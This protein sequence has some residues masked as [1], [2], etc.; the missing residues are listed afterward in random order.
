[1]KK[2]L[3]IGNVIAGR[4]LLVVAIAIALGCAGVQ[5]A[6]VNDLLAFLPSGAQA[7]VGLPSIAAVEQAAAPLLALPMLSEVSTLAVALGGDTLA[8]GL[9]QSGV[10]VNAPAAAFVQVGEG[11]TIQG[12]GVLVVQDAAKLQETL[13]GLLGNAGGEITLP[14]DIKGRFAPDSGVGYFLQGDKFFV[15]TSEPLLQQL[16]TRIAEPAMVSYGK[17]ASKDEVVAF[18]RI[19]I[20]EQSNLLTNVPALAMFKPILDTIK[21]FSDE[22]ILAIGE[23]AGKA[24]IRLAAHDIGNAPIAA[25]APLSLHGFMD[26]G[27][28]AVMNL[29]I[30]PELVNALS[31]TLMNNEA[32]RQAGGYMRIASGMLG[33]ELALS[34]AGMKSE[35]VP[36]A[37]I[38]AKVKSAEGVPNLLKMLA[39]IE[40]PTYK[41]DQTDVY[42][43]P[44][45]SEGTDLHIATAGTTIVVTPGEDALKTAVGRFAGAAAGTG[46]NPEIVNKGV[47]G[48]LMLDGSKAKN[49][50]PDVIPANLNLAD[51]VLALTLGVDND[52]R[53]LVLTAP[54]GFDSVAGVMNQLM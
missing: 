44:N 6:T 40:A 54:G 52:W 21:P 28:P 19:D 49:L 37:V 46:V 36:E 48:F 42:V 33:D 3:S 32:T 31:M 17:N 13:T 38:A 5:A 15:G 51:V 24:Y 47:Y 23:A 29:R 12:C 20:I 14:G 45:V 30:T 1:M 16:A 7:A 8:Q 26:P 22:L 41:L 2:T 9:A 10:D 4:R 53:E 43:Y 35:D 34:F 39:K 50:P 27:A 18:T 25:P 11:N